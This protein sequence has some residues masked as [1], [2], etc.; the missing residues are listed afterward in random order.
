MVGAAAG[1]GTVAG[2]GAMARRLG[3]EGL[4]GSI[5][6]GPGAWALLAALP[7]LV[8]LLTMLTARWTVHRALGEYL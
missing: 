5:S 3:T 4:L 7:L 8:A 2:I 6:F 1:I